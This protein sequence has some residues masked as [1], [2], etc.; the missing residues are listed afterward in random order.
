MN[1]VNALEMIFHAFRS[2]SNVPGEWTENKWRHI[3]FDE[4]KDEKSEVTI[5]DVVWE[6]EDEESEVI[7][8]LD[9]GTTIRDFVIRAKDITEAERNN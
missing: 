2:L 9:D 6:G 5:N 8:S 3:W 1:N 4:D 7:L